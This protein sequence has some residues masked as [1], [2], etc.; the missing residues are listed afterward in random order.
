MYPVVAA[1]EIL[2]G[3]RLPQAQEEYP[4]AMAIDTDEQDALRPESGSAKPL[5]VAS[6]RVMAPIHKVGWRTIRYVLGAI[7]LAYLVRRIVVQG[8]PTDREYLAK[9]VVTGLAITVLGRG[10]RQL[11][12]VLIDWL[13]FTAVLV[14]YDRSR[15][16]ADTAG[17]PLHLTDIAHAEKAVFFGHVPTVWL[18]EHFYSPG[19][20]HWYDAVASLVYSSHFLVT[21]IVAAVLWLS[22][23]TVFYRY[24][25]RVVLLSFAG[26]ATYVLFPEAPPWMASQHGAIGPVTRISALGWTWMHAGFAKHALEAGQNGGSNP[27]A[28]MP[29]LHFA[30]SALAALYVASRLR[31]R[32]RWLV[33]LYPAAMALT[34]VY[35]GE[36]YVLDEIAGALYALAA[37]VVIGRAERWWAARRGAQPVTADLGNAERM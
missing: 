33:W 22:A 20:V 29:S 30:F 19:H 7:F 17:M 8:V 5:A 24:I 18:Q 32:W 3:P 4:S 15:T 16:F 12:W 37:H 2:S 6:R 13:P 10:W 9:L 23:R 14:L 11:L 26:L 34:L 35:T 36:H 27:V 21:P 28:A 1:G 25:S 31:S